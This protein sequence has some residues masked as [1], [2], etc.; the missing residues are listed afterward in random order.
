MVS[1]LQKNAAFVKCG[2]VK[3]RNSKL[4]LTTNNL[5]FG[6]FAELVYDPKLIQGEVDYKTEIV[7]LHFN[8]TLYARRPPELKM[9]E[10]MIADLKAGL[11]ATKLR[12]R[13]IE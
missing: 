12:E 1:I 11:K 13:K 5:S 2:S 8:L 4:G 7:R 9:A 10:D 3:T 6:P